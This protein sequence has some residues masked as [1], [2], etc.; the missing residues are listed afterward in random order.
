MTPG[1]TAPTAVTRRGVPEGA[2]DCHVHVVGPQ[3]AFPQAANRTYLAADAP[4]A[5][6]RALA[7]PLGVRRFVL[8]QPS[9]YGKDN[10]C[11]LQS[12]AALGG[13]GRGVVLLSPEDMTPALLDDYARRG[14]CGLRVNLYTP[15]AAREARPFEVTLQTLAAR[16]PSA[17]HVE[18]IAPLAVLISS[19]P[20]IARSKTRI[21]IDH[22]GLPLGVAPDSP[23]GR[24]LLD[25]FR[26]PHV[27]VKLSAPYRTL[28]DPLATRPRADWLAAILQVAPD[29]CVWGSDWPHTPA[30]GEHLGPDVN[31]PYRPLAYD[32]VLRDFIEADA[33][34]DPA[35][36]KRI[37]L[38]NPVSLYAFA[39]H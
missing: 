14:V 5:S 6:L 33:L 16:L 20:V 23:D 34:S 30:H 27:W 26:L 2:C 15:M 3:D 37:L 17:W 32:R 29:R 28:P 7:E 31:A 36:V 24:A 39:N 13:R 10:R 4:L 38:D 35:I 18:F 25:L 21:V 11:L 9:F 12:L 22:Y 8:V 19:A 1:V